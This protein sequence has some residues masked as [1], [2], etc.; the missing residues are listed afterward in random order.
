[1]IAELTWSLTAGSTVPRLSAGVEAILT[2]SGKCGERSFQV[3]SG[4]LLFSC[5]HPLFYKLFLKQ[6]KK[7]FFS[8]FNMSGPG[9]GFEYPR[10]QVSWLKRDA[11]LFANSIGCKADELHFLYV[12]Q[13]SFLWLEFE[14]TVS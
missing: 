4:G 1:M 7:T 9:V 3:P 6:Q 2:P 12:S 5:S 14:L 13:A 11:L 8:T 10:Q